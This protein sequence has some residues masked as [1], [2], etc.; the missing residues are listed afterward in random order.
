MR[1]CC[2]LRVLAATAAKLADAELFGY[3][4][5][6]LG[7]V[8]RLKQAYHRLHYAHRALEILARNRDSPGEYPRV[9]EARYSVGRAAQ[10]DIFKVQTARSILETRVLKT[11]QGGRGREAEIDMLLGRDPRA[12]LAAPPE[13]LTVT[14]DELFRR[15]SLASPALKREQKMVERTELAVRLARKDYYSDYTLSA[16]YFNMGR[17]PACFRRKQ[18]NG[19]A[20]Q[21]F[22]GR[23]ACNTL[24]IGNLEG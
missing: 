1:S 21:V 6:R 24:A 10:R 3:E 2:I 12:R 9:A 4:Q 7:V 17:M 8:S 15:A 11:E 16:G 5:T 19:V 18:R 14:L 22:Q 20:G 13:A 23:R